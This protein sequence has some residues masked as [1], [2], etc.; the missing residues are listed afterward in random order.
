MADPRAESPMETRLRLV[1]AGLPRP[2]VQYRVVNEYGI[3]LVRVDL[4]YPSARLTIE[5]DGSE[6]YTRRRGERDHQWTPNRP[7]TAGAP[8]GGAGRGRRGS[9]RPPDPGPHLAAHTAAGGAGKPA[10][11]NTRVLRSNT[12][13][14]FDSA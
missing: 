6:H 13:L 5:Y 11:L 4:A 1:R 12:T 14:V 10:D 3:V 7:T 9:D 8:C 2:D